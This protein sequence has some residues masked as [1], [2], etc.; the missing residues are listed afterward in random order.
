MSYVVRQVGNSFYSTRYIRSLFSFV[1]HRTPKGTAIDQLRENE[2]WIEDDLPSIS[3]FPSFF[4]VYTFK[5][6]A[7][8]S[9]QNKIQHEISRD[10]YI[11][12]SLITYINFCTICSKIELERCHHH[13]YNLR[14]FKIVCNKIQMNL[15]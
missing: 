13:K 11:E 8:F 12:K 6:S 2:T 9:S 4:I 7:L 10:K 1:R 3:S 5:Y 15:R 14:C